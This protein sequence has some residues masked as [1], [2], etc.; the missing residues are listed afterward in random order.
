MAHT[1]EKTWITA[2]GLNAVVLM[3]DGG[4]HRCGYVA[5]PEGHPLHG[6]G[7]GSIEDDIDVHGGITFAGGRNG[8]PAEGDGLWWFGY[9]CAHAGD[10]PGPQYVEMMRSQYPNMS[11][12]CYDDDGVHRDLAY[13]EV[14][15][16]RLAAQL[17]V[18]RGSVQAELLS[19]LEHIAECYA[20]SLSNL[21][22]AEDEALAAARAAIARATG[23]DHGQ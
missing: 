10:A 12:M 4:R 13:C 2:A 15:C 20:S 18:A 1:V 23:A 11:Y 9:D 6:V 7:Y 8:Y 21:G 16:E 19:A 3:V 14:E 17:A 5:V 22:Q